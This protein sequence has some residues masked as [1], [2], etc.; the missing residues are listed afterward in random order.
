VSV[1]LESHLRHSIGSLLR[2]R[3]DTRLTFRFGLA[4]SLLRSIAIET[5]SALPVDSFG[6]PISID[7][8]TFVLA[9]CDVEYTNVPAI[10]QPCSRIKE[11]SRYRCYCSPWHEAQQ[12]RMRLLDSLVK[13]VFFAVELL[14]NSSTRESV[15]GGMAADLV[16]V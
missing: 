11:I 5:R 2:V 6:V 14:A 16:I 7:L 3:D 15:H 4:L 9:I 1:V 8:L 10:C 12:F 13:H